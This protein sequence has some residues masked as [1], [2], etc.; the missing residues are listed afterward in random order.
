MADKAT[1]RKYGPDLAIEIRS[2]RERKDKNSHSLTRIT[3]F[4]LMEALRES[5]D[6]ALLSLQGVGQG[7]SGLSRGGRFGDYRGYEGLVFTPRL[8]VYGPRGL[9][10]RYSART[11]SAG[12]IVKTR[13]VAAQAAANPINTRNAAPAIKVHGSGV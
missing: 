3:L 2:D 1:V 5:Q 10:G 9:P 4:V 7:L 6:G 12:S 8:P 11:A 13:V